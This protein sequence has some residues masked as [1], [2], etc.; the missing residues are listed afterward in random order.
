MTNLNEMIEDLKRRRDE[1]ALKIHLGSKDAQ[2]EWDE[3]EKKWSAFQNDAE[4]NESGKA[5]GG[6]I[7]QLGSELEKA[8]ERLKKAL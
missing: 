5:I 7:D 2:D 8:Y 3:L 6:A 1:L 4:L